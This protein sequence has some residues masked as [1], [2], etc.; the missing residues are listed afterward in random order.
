MDVSFGEASRQ[1]NPDAGRLVPARVV[2]DEYVDKRVI[3]AGESKVLRSREPRKRPEVLRQ[4]SHPPLLPHGE[5]TV[6][7]DNDLTAA[8]LPAAGADVRADG[9]DVVPVLA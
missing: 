9:V 7:E 3:E 8:P 1:V 5:W 2:R 6:V 4:H